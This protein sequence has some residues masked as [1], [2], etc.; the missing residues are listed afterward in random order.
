MLKIEKL[1]R[2][3]QDRVQPQSFP[4]L[5]VIVWYEPDLLLVENTDPALMSVW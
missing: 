1:N 3:T 2:N 4:D 5:E